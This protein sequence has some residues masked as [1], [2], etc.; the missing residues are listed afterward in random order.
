MD[1]PLHEPRARAE[2]GFTLVEMMAALAILLFGITA[3]IG[4]LTSS[5]AQRR[6]TDARLETTALC[7]YALMRLREEAIHL[8]EGATSDLDLELVPLQDQTAPDFPGMRWS[9][10]AIVDEDRPDV[11]L[12]RLEV[13]WFDEGD[14]VTQEFLRVLPRQQP[15]RARVLRFTGQD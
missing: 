14:D 1:R 2:A 9:A 11:W 5:V 7:D 13:R 3:L 8:R 15:L 12:V 4:A 6:T 10:K